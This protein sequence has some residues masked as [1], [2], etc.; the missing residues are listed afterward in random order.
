M[1][2][3]TNDIQRLIQLKEHSEN[4]RKIADIL[5]AAINDW[6]IPTLT[7]VEY[8]L[9]VQKFIGGATTKHNIETTLKKIDFSKYSWQ[10]ESLSQALEI[11]K[12]Y[13]DRETLCG[14]IKNLEIELGES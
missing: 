2:I 1:N 9:E 7:L 4:V 14:V 3:I 8:E 11:F 5:L 13:K 6:P 10:A 12:F